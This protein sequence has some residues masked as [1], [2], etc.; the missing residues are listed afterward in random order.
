[1]SWSDAVFRSR[2][3]GE[4]RCLDDKSA[5]GERLP[6]PIRK[7]A[8]DQRAV[9]READRHG[10]RGAPIRRTHRPCHYRAIYNGRERSHADTDG[11][12]HGRHDLRR[13]SSG[14]M[15]TL[16]DLALQAGGRGFESHHLHRVQV[17]AT[18][19][20]SVATYGAFP[21]LLGS[22]RAP[23]HGPPCAEER[24]DPK[25]SSS[26]NRQRDTGVLVTPPPASGVVCSQ[27]RIVLPRWAG[28]RPTAASPSPLPRTSAAPPAPRSGC[29]RCSPGRGSSVGCRCL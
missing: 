4:R 25:P 12:S 20:E 8:A 13:P 5:A 7:R 19:M 1:M 28:S 27:V 14:Q 6:K 2:P 16:P 11:H 26:G 18:T 29:R 22:H 24:H 21:G 3:A 17:R 10:E 23:P 9:M 15:T